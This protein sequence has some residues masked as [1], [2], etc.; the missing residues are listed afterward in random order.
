MFFF[1]RTPE[2]TYRK[3]DDEKKQT[4]QGMRKR[5]RKNST[6]FS[7]PLE[8]ETSLDEEQKKKKA[9]QRV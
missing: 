9:M 4:V 1:R 7:I 8:Q 3:Y 5:G 6:R 2:C